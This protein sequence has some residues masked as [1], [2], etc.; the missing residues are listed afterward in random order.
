MSRYTFN[1]KLDPNRDRNRRL[2]I[3]AIA[4]GA[5]VLLAIALLIF[6]ITQLTA[7]GGSNAAEPT[8]FV[9]QVTIFA[10]QG[11]APAVPQDPGATSAAPADANPPDSAASVTEATP[12]APAVTM[13]PRGKIEGI[14]DFVCPNP[15]PAPATFG[16]GIQSN[17]PVGDIGLFNTIMAEQLKM[18]WTKAQVRWIDFEP[19]QGKN[20]LYKWQL[21]DA[22]TADANQKGLNILYGILDAPAWTR[23]VNEP[24]LLGPP[25]DYNE[26][27]RFFQKVAARYKGCVQAIEVWNEMNLDREW[28]IPSR[29]IQASDYVQFLDAVV[30]A[31]RE[32]DPST[33]VL[34]GALS[35]TGANITEG[36]ITKVID[37]LTY[38]DQ[39]VA[40]GGPQ[41]VDCIGIHLN[42]YNM[43][44]DKRHDEGFNDPTAK[45]R[46]PFDS[47]HPS[48]SFKSTL[49]EYHKK[50][51]MPI[52][53][54]EFGWASMENLKRKDGTPTQ[55]APPGFDFALDNTE[56]EQADWIVQAFQIMKDSGYVKFGIVFNLDYIQKVGG[57]PDQENVSPYSITRRDGSPRPAFEALKVMPR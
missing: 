35:P 37:D 23:S 31:I 34:M 14:D 54:T 53:A 32:I 17:W 20:E 56:Q 10:P 6:G 22:F 50:T 39:F 38:M 5:V 40:A 41:R 43:P 45:F 4:F 3:G 42:G 52:C 44:P 36:N 25:D 28:T 30:P 18:D 47:P 1:P 16:Y 21:L 2:A 46:G 27:K 33:I 51:N 8:E 49:E 13:D 55:G 7:N 12:A 48:W 19:E 29:K 11:Q 24:G 15:R 57:E 26:A 9:P